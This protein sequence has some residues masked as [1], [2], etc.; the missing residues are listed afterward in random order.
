[1]RRLLLYINAALILSLSTWQITYSQD[2]IKFPD[3]VLNFPSRFFDKIEKKYAS[4][5]AKLTRQ[6]ERYLKRLESKEKKLKKKLAKID[7]A[8]AKQL[9]TNADAKYQHFIN[10]IKDSATLPKTA[11][12]GEYKPFADSLKTGLSFLAQNNEVIAASHAIQDKIQSSLGQ[13]NQLQSKLKYS[14]E[15]KAYI[16]QRKQVLNE[17]IGGYAKVP[18]S[19]L[20]SFNNYKSEAYYYTKQIKEYRD[21]FNKEPEKLVKKGLS[22]LNRL[23]L[24]QQFMKQHSELS[25]LFNLPSNYSNAGNIA[26]LQTRNQVQQ[27]IQTQITSAGPNGAQLLQQNLQAAQEGLNTL[28]DKIKQFG[29]GSGDLDMP[30]FKPNN[31]RTKSFWKRLEYG[32]NLQT[33][34]NH[35][36]PTT[37]DLGLS[38]GYKLT[39]KSSFGIGASYKMGWGKDIRHIIITQQGMS[40]R[41]YIELKLKGSFYATGGF[42]YNYQPLPTDS[43]LSPPLWKKMNPQAWQRSGLIG[44]SKIVSIKSKFFKKTK[45]QL[46]WDFLSYQQ[47]PRP[48][49][50]KFRVGYSF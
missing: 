42:E 2:Q 19:I 39:D 1:M 33:V 47:L 11:V 20:K 3:K 5:D 34:K 21:A 18:H 13:V 31:Q 12:S 24:Y 44:V 48:Q 46:L 4:L 49:P 17:A 14:D 38:V 29:Q 43:L 27:L 30:D 8:K 35:F 7:P 22:L 32:T 6:T 36:F 16:R 37:T 15:I 10:K 45:L 26:G 50:I 9:F 28:K 23:P 25:G 41:S 40:L